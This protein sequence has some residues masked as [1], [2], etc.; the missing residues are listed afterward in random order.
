MKNI[1]SYLPDLN[2]KKAGSAVLSTA[3][4]NHVITQYEAMIHEQNW[5]EF[6]VYA[7]ETHAVHILQHVTVNLVREYGEELCS[8]VYA[9]YLLKSRAE[10]LL[11]SVN[12]IMR[13]ATNHNWQA[14]TE[15][16]CGIGAPRFTRTVAPISLDPVKFQCAV[17]DV[18]TQV[19]ER[20][21]IIIQLIRF[22][23]IS[24]RSAAFLDVS[25]A[26]E[27]VNEDGRISLEELGAPPGTDELVAVYSKT[28]MEILK[29]SAA[30]A[31]GESCLLPKGQPWTLWK[32]TYIRKA[33]EILL[34]HGINFADLHAAFA[35]DLYE[36]YSAHEAPVLGGRADRDLDL[37]VRQ[38][39]ADELGFSRIWETDAYLG[40][41]P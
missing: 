6:C 25:S 2:I 38:H 26:L 4:Q 20:A 16:A 14:V 1:F 17:S 34:S 15:V 24:S 12:T 22:F 10:G 27:A 18:R 9:D 13:L 21:A 19:S 36:H 3:I 41:R 35:C 5:G 7:E 28:Q 31:Y 29:K 39:V 32:K 37:E 11:E 23:G 30:I 40:A 8:H 33:K